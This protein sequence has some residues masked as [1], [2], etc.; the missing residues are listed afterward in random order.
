MKVTVEYIQVRETEIKS[1]IGN[2]Y[3]YTWLL[4][5]II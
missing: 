3:K 1:Q 5:N 4:G 2:M